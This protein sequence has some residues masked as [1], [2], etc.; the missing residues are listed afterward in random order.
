MDDKRRKIIT[1]FLFAFMLFF[2]V[3]AGMSGNIQAEIIKAY[4]LDLEQASLFI[5]FQEIGS[6]L[7]MLFSVLVADRLKKDRLVGLLLLLMGLF[8]LL[9]GTAPIFLLLLFAKTGSYVFSNIANNTSSAY[10]SDLYHSESSQNMSLLHMLFGVGA[11]IGPLYA[12]LIDRAGYGWNGSHLLLG[13][14]VLL[15]VAGYVFLLRKQKVQADAATPVGR[16]S[17]IPLRAMLM[18]GNMRVL[19]IVGACLASYQLFITWLPTYL[20]N[21]DTVLY[22]VERSSFIITAYYV[23]MIISRLC[24]SALSKKVSTHAYVRF[25]CL[26][27]V[28]ILGISLFFQTYQLWLIGNFLLGLTSGALYTAQFIL[29]CKQFP[30]FS[31]GS[32]SMVSL[33]SALGAMLVNSV[34]GVVAGRGAFTEAMYIPVIMI[35]IAFVLMLS[36][37]KP[38]QIAPDSA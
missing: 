29:V 34:I 10:I 23:G 16:Q 21:Q 27:S 18:D 4:Q 13:G 37:Y 9:V 1:F 28:A 35:A 3:S 22:T 2:G 26:T 24:Y 25:A 6:I 14:A 30:A 31:A 36:F 15:F 32:S 38:K 12:T 33:F 19:C 20:Y 5:T 11:L 7:A 8:N 17:R